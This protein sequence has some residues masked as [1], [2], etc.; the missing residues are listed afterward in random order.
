[1]LQKERVHVVILGGGFGG[2]AA[3]RKLNVPGVRVTLIDRCNHHLFQPLL[4]QVATAALSAPDISTPI[5]HLLQRQSNVTV[6]MGTVQRIEVASKRIVLG[7]QYLDYDYLI[8]A[9]GMTHNYFGNDRWAKF[10]PSLKTISEALDIRRRILRAFEAAEL[11]NDAAARR[12]WTTFVVIGG[13]PTGVELAGA[14]AEI[15]GRTLARDFRRFDPRTT[16]VI[17]VEAGPR[18]LAG[19]PEELSGKAKEHLEMLGIEV[20]LGTRV[21]DIAESVVEIGQERIATRTVLWAAGVRATAL[22][23]DLGVPLDGAG[24]VL[25]EDDLSVPGRPELFVVGDLIAKNQNGRPLP[26]V[27]QLALQSGRHAA[28]NLA[29]SLI[30][31]PRLPF[32]YLDKGMM[33]TIGRNRAVAQIGPFKSSGVV[34]WFLWLTVHLL[35]LI[36]FRSRLAV[37]I[38]WA[39]AYF[40]W[41]RRSRV[42]LEAP[43][44]PPPAMIVP[45]PGVRT[46]SRAARAG[47]VM[48]PD[49][50]YEPTIV[51]PVSPTDSVGRRRG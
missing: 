35:S 40:T 43:G 51:D 44:V 19:F 16:R 3:A 36:G 46:E 30:G 23:A 48:R 5:R 20:R 32:H 28:R 34:A 24:R 21:T 26:G 25:V 13:G 15:A 14:L 49:F 1:M 45:M 6:F 18:L 29:F 22:T 17:L 8:L 9:T 33:A 12:A 27:A 42:I 7:G 2:L 39:L 4:Y 11:E 10:A 37:L 50:E 38:E 41:K 47:R 31:K